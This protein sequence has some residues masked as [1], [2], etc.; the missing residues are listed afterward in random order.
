M[1]QHRVQVRMYNVCRYIQ[2]RPATPLE[3]GR[4]RV[5]AGAVANEGWRAEAWMEAAWPWTLTLYRRT[6]TQLTVS[7][8]RVASPYLYKHAGL[9]R[10][11]SMSVRP[12]PVRLCP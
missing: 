6:Y 12:P 1:A 11:P 5:A 4:V 10:W 8:G 3:C 7:S 9:A 2:T